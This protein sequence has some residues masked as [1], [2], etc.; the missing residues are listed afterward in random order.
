MNGPTNA[1]PIQVKYK[2]RSIHTIFIH[3]NRNESEKLECFF[4]AFLGL[5]EYGGWMGVELIRQKY[6]SEIL[7]IAI[8]YS[9]YYAL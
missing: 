8:I 1:I 3:I 6:G 5:D 9:N 4:S 7:I 2:F